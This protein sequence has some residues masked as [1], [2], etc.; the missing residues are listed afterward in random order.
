MCVFFLNA[1]V[2]RDQ[3]YGRQQVTDSCF[4]HFAIPGVSGIILVCAGKS[5]VLFRGTQGVK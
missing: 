4:P 5:I 3:R 1:F 2:P